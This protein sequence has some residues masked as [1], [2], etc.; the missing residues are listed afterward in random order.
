VD[1][2]REILRAAGVECHDLTHLNKWSDPSEWDDVILALARLVA[3]YKWQRD[4]IGRLWNE[5]GHGEGAYF[6]SNVL[7]ELGWPEDNDS[8]NGPELLVAALDRRWEERHD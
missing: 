3:Q 2:P 8:E 4:E 7:T 1:D 5:S 6:I